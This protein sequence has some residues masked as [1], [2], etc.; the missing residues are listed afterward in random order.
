MT[1]Q[2]RQLRQNIRNAFLT[3]SWETMNAALVNYPDQ[4]SKDCLRELM[5]EVA[6]PVCNN[7][8]TR[9]GQHTY[10]GSCLCKK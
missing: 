5:G 3:E 4:F 2:Q 1:Q 6:C 9:G 7:F 8:G 10:D